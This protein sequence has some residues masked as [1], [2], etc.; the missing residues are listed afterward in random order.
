M[1]PLD[2][3]MWQRKAKGERDG[4]CRTCRAAYKKAHYAAN[5]DRYLAN[6]TLRNAKVLRARVA[7]LLD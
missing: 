6:A 3:F 7:W 1:K 5:N 4:Y 2:D